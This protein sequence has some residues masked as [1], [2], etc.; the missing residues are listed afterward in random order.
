MSLGYKGYGKLYGCSDGYIYYMYSGEDW[1]TVIHAGP[2]A[3][4]GMIRIEEASLFAAEDAFYRAVRSGKIDTPRACRN[5]FGFNGK[6]VGYIAY[7]VAYHIFK[8]YERE[9]R[10]PERVAFAQ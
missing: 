9:A 7:L 10:L 3:A 4:D 6:G 5:E 2:R 8:E 1:E